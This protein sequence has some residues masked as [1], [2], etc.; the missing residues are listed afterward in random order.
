MIIDRFASR[1]E[2]NFEYYFLG[3]TSGKYI[4]FCSNKELEVGA[5]VIIDDLLSTHILKVSSIRE[6]HKKKVVEFENFEVTLCSQ[7]LVKYDDLEW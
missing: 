1:M 3:D 4:Q 5:P 2:K 6:V 7:T